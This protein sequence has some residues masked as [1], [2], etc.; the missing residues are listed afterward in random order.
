MVGILVAAVLA[1][2]TFAVCTSLELPVVVGIVF[3]VIVLLG[4][5]PMLGGRFGLRD[6]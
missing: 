4:S 2:L 1:A 6:L 3:A 5:L